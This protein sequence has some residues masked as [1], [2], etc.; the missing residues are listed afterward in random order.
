MTTISTINEATDINVKF[1]IVKE[2]NQ[3]KNIQFTIK[4]FETKSSI[5][6]PL[7]LE[8]LN[9]KY[10]NKNITL[11]SSI[12]TVKTVELQEGYVIAS[13]YSKELNLVG[14]LKFKTLEDCDGY[15]EREVVI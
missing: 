7:T 8:N 15:F 12:F 4:R 2:N 10:F 14:K 6:N 13:V 1:K 3:S 5:Q 11:N 9:L